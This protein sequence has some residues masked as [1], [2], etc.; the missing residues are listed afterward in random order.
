MH[1]SQNASDPAVVVA[2]FAADM[3]TAVITWLTANVDTV[4]ITRLAADM[5]AVIIPR[6]SMGTTATGVRASRT[7]MA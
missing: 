3:D 2:G 1:E 4:V 7:G 5:I 6:F